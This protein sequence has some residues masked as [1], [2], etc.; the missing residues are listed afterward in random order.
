[1]A[2]ITRKYN[3]QN[4]S[5]AR[6]VEDTAPLSAVAQLGYVDINSETGEV[7]SSKPTAMHPIP[8]IGEPTYTQEV[9]EPKLLPIGKPSDLKRRIMEAV[10]IGHISELYGA[11]PEDTE[12]D[13]NRFCNDDSDDVDNFNQAMS[14]TPY[15]CDENGL[16]N[17]EKAIAQDKENAMQLEELMAQAQT[18]LMKQFLNLSEDDRAKA[19]EMVAQ[20]IGKP[21]SDAGGIQPNGSEGDS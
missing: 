20:T 15:H 13:W 1:M 18:P 9:G 21:V 19:M 5:K 17:F 7:L 12:D 16:A 6:S 10:K 3:W 11:E 8:R 4:T 14:Q 2:K